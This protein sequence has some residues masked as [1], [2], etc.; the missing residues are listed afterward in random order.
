MHRALER[1]V[2]GAFEWS[3][4]DGLTG[5]RTLHEGRTLM[6][7][8]RRLKHIVVLWSKARTHRIRLLRAISRI[9]GLLLKWERWSFL[10]LIAADRRM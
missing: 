10:V 2:H 1:A 8:Q 4:I 7:V 9:A 5:R 3:A 6:V